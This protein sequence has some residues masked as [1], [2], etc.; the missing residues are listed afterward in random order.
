MVTR[1][2]GLKMQDEKGRA[3]RRA[4]GPFNLVILTAQAPN[5]K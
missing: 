2:E 3:E 4:P 5:A 1:H